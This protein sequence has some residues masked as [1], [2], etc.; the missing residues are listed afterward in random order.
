MKRY[1]RRGLAVY[2]SN[3]TS[4]D[5]LNQSLLRRPTNN[6]PS[7]VA[8][9]SSSALGFSPVVCIHNKFPYRGSHPRQLDTCES[10]APP[11]KGEKEIES[12]RPR[13]LI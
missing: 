8:I 1:I 6:H 3:R 4:I 11:A 7:T 2:G 12:K 9:H 10:L 5:T 13:A